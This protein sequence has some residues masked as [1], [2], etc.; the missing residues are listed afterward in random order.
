MAPSFWFIRRGG[1]TR[2]AARYVAKT[3][4][5][6]LGRV[7]YGAVTCAQSVA[8]RRNLAEESMPGC[9]TYALM[10]TFTMGFAAGPGWGRVLTVGTS[11]ENLNS[12]NSRT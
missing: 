9:K 10:S 6:L 5:D 3:S 2:L 7:V 12:V 8:L 11:Y 4:G 1:V